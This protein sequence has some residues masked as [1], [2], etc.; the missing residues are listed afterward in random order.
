MS[1]R[2]GALVLS[3]CLLA[4]A[5]PSPGEFRLPK[6]PM[7]SDTSPEVRRAIQRLYS[8]DAE[9]RL[10]ATMSLAELGPK[11]VAAVPFLRDLL[12]DGTRISLTTQHA[13]EG[14]A[15][16][17]F[18]TVGRIAAGALWDIR[19]HDFLGLLRERNARVRCCA[20]ESL[21]ERGRGQEA[22]QLLL[23]AMSDPDPKVRKAAAW[24][25]G[26]SPTPAVR[27]ALVRATTDRSA[28]VRMAAAFSLGCMGSVD[29]DRRAGA[30]LA[31]LI[32]FDRDKR[33]RAAAAWSLGQLQ[34]P[35]AK[36]ALERAMKDPDPAVRRFAKIALHPGEAD[37]KQNAEIILTLWRD[38]GGP[39]TGTT[40]PTPRPRPEPTAASAAPADAGAAAGLRLSGV[41]SG[42]NGKV[43]IINGRPVGLGQTVLGATVVKIDSFSVELERGGRR[44]TVSR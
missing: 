23:A 20:V 16:F 29:R 32:Q 38:E 25:L 26:R 4:P 13:P 35:R 27:K 3:A 11:A 8:P 44:F 7:P 2:I 14:A 31:H 30:L 40:K 9:Q 36:T 18:P 28:G 39:A 37:G 5:G 34:D 22:T 10:R 42:P 43:A 24:G 1:I 17:G 6:R 15:V 19:P 21:A 41:M 12:L 33:C